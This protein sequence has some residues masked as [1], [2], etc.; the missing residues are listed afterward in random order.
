MLRKIR[1]VIKEMRKGLSTLPEDFFDNKDGIRDKLETALNITLPTNAPLQLS[2]LEL[3]LNPEMNSSSY[4]S[5]VIRNN[6]RNMLVPLTIISGIKTVYD[7]KRMR[8]GKSAVL[9]SIFKY[10]DRK[11]QERFG[12]S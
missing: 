8:E 12:R 7:I 9:N 5:E 1:Y 11:I 3:M 10:I 4:V 2:I 6:Y